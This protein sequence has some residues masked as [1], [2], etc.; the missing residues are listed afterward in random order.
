MNPIYDRRGQVVAWLDDENIYHLNGRH[1][2]VV[3]GNNVYGHRG[4]HLGVLDHGLFRD[5]RGG[6]VA[7]LEGATGGPILPIPSN[8]AYPTHTIHST[9]SCHSLNPA[10]TSNSVVR[11]GANSMAAVHQCL[12]PNM[13]LQLTAHSRASAELWR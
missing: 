1:A 12:A 6:A 10:Y 4:Q 3:D 8:P 5:H 9:N 11:L 13:A 7:F 2:G